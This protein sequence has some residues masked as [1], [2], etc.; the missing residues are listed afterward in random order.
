MTAPA[1]VIFGAAFGMAG[2]LADRKWINGDGVVNTY[3]YF[4]IIKNGDKE[5]LL[6]F[7]KKAWSNLLS[8][9]RLG[10][11]RQ[12]KFFIPKDSWREA[13]R[14]STILSSLMIQSEIRT[15]VNR[16]FLQIWYKKSSLL[17]IL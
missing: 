15:A 3:E 5:G 16:L 10:N 1:N 6:R 14:K 8:M 4:H 17:Y 7:L 13:E 12:K 9:R 11:S 2:F